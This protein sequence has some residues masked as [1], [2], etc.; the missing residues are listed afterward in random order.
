MRARRTVLLSVIC[1]LFLGA[2]SGAAF[3][4]RTI[5]MYNGVCDVLGGFPGMLQ[6]AGFVTKGTC[7]FEKEDEG[8]EGK[9]GRECS[10]EPCRVNG[11]KGHCVKRL[12]QKKPRCVCEPNHISKL[13]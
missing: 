4:L 5:A 7:R 6:S 8:Q 1:L 10:E 11:K 2:A 12:V 13:I 3:T 9:E